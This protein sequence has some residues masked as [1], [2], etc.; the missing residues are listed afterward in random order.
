MV[1]I[2]NKYAKIIGIAGAVILAGCLIWFFYGTPTQKSSFSLDVKS[3]PAVWEYKGLYATPELVA[4]TDKNIANL[5][6]KLK[7]SGADKYDLYVSLAQQ[8]MLIGR[9]EESYEYLLRAGDEDPGNSITF[10]TMG[11]LMESLG[12]QSAAEEAFKQAIVVQP[13]IVQNHLALIGFYIR[14]NAEPAEID[15]AFTYALEKSGKAVNVLKEYAQWLEGEKDMDK[16]VAT[17]EEVLIR[18]PNNSAIKDKIAEL[19]RKL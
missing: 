14:Q 3:L 11:T 13:Q 5:K 15:T 12:A 6:E 10:Q 4:Q 1:F 2:L 9:G 16:A 8:Y 17:W 18:E 19:K 7:E